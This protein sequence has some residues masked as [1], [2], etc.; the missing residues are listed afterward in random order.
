M[1]R[2]LNEP[3]AYA[4]KHIYPRFKKLA[5]RFEAV[6][7]RA[8]PELAGDE[9]FWRVIFVAGA[10]HY[11]LHIWNTDNLPLKPDKQIDA[12][13]L[14]GQLIAFASAGLQAR[15]AY[16]SVKLGASAHI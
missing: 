10:L 5:V 9:V 7:A 6:I 2:C 11:A 13:E 15:V 4:E 1:G 3:P 14:I 12:E 8:V 16:Q